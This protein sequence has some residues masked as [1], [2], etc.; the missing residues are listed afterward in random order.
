[1]QC[2]NCNLMLSLI[3]NISYDNYS[4]VTPFL[5][6]YKLL[7]DEMPRDIL[8]SYHSMIAHYISAETLSFEF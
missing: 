1:M 3:L 4:N 8:S 5:D 2:Y 6:N 7:L